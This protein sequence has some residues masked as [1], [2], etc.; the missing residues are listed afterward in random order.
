MSKKKKSES[1]LQV[2]VNEEFGDIRAMMIDGEVWF[3][4]KDVATALGYKDTKNAL[5]SHVKPSHKKGW[6]ITT[7]SRGEQKMTLIDEAGLYSLIMRSKLPAAED[8]QEWVTSEVLPAIRKTGSYVADKDFQ[9]LLQVHQ[10]YLKARRDETGTIKVFIEY[11]RHQGCTENE[12]FFYGLLS[13]WVNLGVGL[14]ERRGRDKANIQQ[15]SAITLLEGTVIINILVNGMADKLHWTQIWAKAKKQ[16]NLF[17]EVTFQSS[18]RL[19]PSDDDWS[20]T[21]LN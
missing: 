5:K 21:Y 14:P 1:A 18:P 8:F 4:G 9:K 10:N 12:G 2:Y 15:K 19:N 16:I 3:V 7:P 17:L 13:K 20:L 11:A 6:Q